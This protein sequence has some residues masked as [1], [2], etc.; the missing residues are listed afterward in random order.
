M[1]ALYEWIVTLHDK[2]D[3]DGFYEDMETPGGS[4]TI[5]D[6]K[7]DV[8]NRREISRNTHY[9]LTY[10]EA[11]EVKND[12]RVWGVELLEMVENTI[13]P[14]GWEMEQESFNK[15]W[16]A[17]ANDFNWGLLKHTTTNA[18]GS[19]GDNAITD[20]VTVS[21]S[22]KNVDVV[23]FDGHV[24]PSH[25]EFA[26]N[27]DGSGGSRVNQIN[28]FAYGGSGTYTYDRSGSYTNSTD[29]QE[30][31]HG[32]HVAGTVAGNTQGWARDAAIYNISPYGNNPNG[33]ISGTMWDYVRAWH[34]AKSVNPATGRKNP[35]V[36]N[37]SYGTVNETN[38]INAITYRGTAFNPGRTL[39]VAELNARGC[40]A[41]STTVEVPYYS[42]SRFADIQ[43]AIDDGII[44]VF[45][46]GNEYWKTVA[47]TDQDYNNDYTYEYF[48][49]NFTEWLHRGTASG[50]GYAPCITVGAL[51]NNAAEDKAHFSNCGTGV[52]IFAGGEAIQSSLLTASAYGGAD[53]RNGS[54]YLAKYQGTSMASPQVC[55][56]LACLAEYWPG[57]TQTAAADWL[58]NNA[59]NSVMFDTGTDNAMDTDSL[60]GAPNK[61]LKWKNQRA[62]T[63]TSF[64]RKNYGGR[65]SSGCLYPRARIRKRG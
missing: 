7:V 54:Y 20:D 51:S 16:S 23:I 55:G 13:R 42:T 5:P 8:T 39:T 26:V 3:L 58:V 29:L 57:M 2:N 34:N 11:M 28:W 32:T 38:T 45:A 59:E 9:M 50:G 15:A 6:R 65:N 40:Y 21:A 4:I 25:P 24:D 64:P 14:V 49:F 30:N 36:T 41:T 52:D 47:S 63:G 60:Q 18:N 1:S 22:G 53:P 19:W 27:P 61:I 48:G 43:D 31:N 10:E 17:N 37:H 62:L 56:V 46:A 44:V 12:P 35:T 33:N